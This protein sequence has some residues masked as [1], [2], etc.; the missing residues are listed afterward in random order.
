[1]KEVRDGEWFIGND[2]DGCVSY[3]IR[4]FLTDGSV[5][6]V[7]DIDCALN[8]IPQ[9]LERLRGERIDTVQLRYIIEDYIAEIYLR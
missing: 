2:E 5:W 3:G 4:L 1:M 7:A 8:K 9:M 6:E